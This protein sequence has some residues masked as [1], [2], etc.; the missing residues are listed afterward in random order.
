VEARGSER[1]S[2]PRA[3]AHGGLM[4]PRLLLTTVVS[5]AAAAVV[6][7]F[8]LLGIPSAGRGPR[9]E[10]RAGAPF[11]GESRLPE[12]AAPSLQGA[13]QSA[14]EERRQGSSCRAVISVADEGGAPV[15]GAAIVVRQPGHPLRSDSAVQVVGLGMTDSNGTAM[16]EGAD[17]SC[18][19]WRISITKDRFIP[20]NG[21]LRAD[22][23]R[24][25][26]RK[27]D[28][29]E[30]RVMTPEGD[31]I[32]GATVQLQQSRAGVAWSAAEVTSDADGG[33]SFQGGADPEAR[34]Q[35]LAAW[36]PDR[37]VRVVRVT[38]AIPRQDVVLA[39]GDAFRFRLLLG[40]GG[41]PVSDARV[42]QLCGAS[43]W[44]LVAT[45]DPEGY[46]ALRGYSRRGHP[47]LL[48][49]DAEGSS[50]L[51]RFD[52]VP[53]DSPELTISAP[54]TASGTVS[55]DGKQPGEGASVQLFTDSSRYPFGAFLDSLRTSAGA[56]GRFAM[57]P[58][59]S[60]FSWVYQAR[61]STNGPPAPPSEDVERVDSTG[62]AFRPEGDAWV[63]FAEGP[64]SHT[65]LPVSME[66]AENIDVRLDAGVPIRISAA[67]DSADFLGRGWRPVLLPWH[68]EADGQER[69]G[70]YGS[71][72][73]RVGAYAGVFEEDGSAAFPSV[74]VGQYAL[75]AVDDLGS[76]MSW[77]GRLQVV[78]DHVE[79]TPRWERFG[80]DGSNR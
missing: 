40:D 4:R 35:V 48:R 20:L 38:K 25:T 2:E 58:A 32:P 44:R 63:L 76:Q 19:P 7:L 30:G 11:T 18:P 16:I 12:P 66:A 50:F 13:P 74:P 9:T 64:T 45:S 43:I 52:V 46:V 80:A 15:G 5:L 39:S 69:S 77:G 70:A 49:V 22:T 37:E 23:G 75:L 55:Y 27:G 41:S 78:K 62:G 51:V 33:F 68:G 24:F 56:D 3:L 29:L 1:S 17:A 10:P 36:A 67:G 59:F 42:Y 34:E 8:F 53:L 71:P 6:F 14:R 21:T 26:L 65:V 72:L 61:R 79:W 57:G 28:T 60:T 73:D 47:G 54:R 31:G